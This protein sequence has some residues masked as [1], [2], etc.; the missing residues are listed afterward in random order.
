MELVALVIGHGVRGR[1]A[2]A[3]ATAVLRDVGGI[4]G[5]TKTSAS[6]L[7][8]NAGVGE[9][10]AGRVLAAVELGR[11][12]LFI[13]PDAKLPLRSPE[14]LGEFLIPRFGASSVERFG[15][16]LLDARH[17]LMRVH[18][19]SEGGL[20]AAVATPREV[21]REA[22]ITGASAIV[23]FHNHPSGDPTPTASDVELTRRLIDA[24]R[25][26]GIDV[27]DHLVLADAALVSIRRA[28]LI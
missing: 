18:I 12:T 15:V 16:V 6:R 13:P 23:A 28:K 14:E 3:V 4:H 24:G 5:L 25:I 2:V 19:V 7:K 17:R 21:F 8:L 26:V 1:S 11:R 22:T 20:D 27:L 9:A 10:Q